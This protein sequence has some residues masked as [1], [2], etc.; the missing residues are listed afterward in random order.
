MLREDPLLPHLFFISKEFVLNE[1]SDSLDIINTKRITIFSQSSVPS[2]GGFITQDR[3]LELR[4]KIKARRK[5][6]QECKGSLMRN[7]KYAYRFGRS[8]LCILHVHFV[9]IL[10][11]SLQAYG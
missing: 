5:Q 10:A 8:L 11:H 7:I 2:V 4:H 9:C 3:P 6:I 1:I